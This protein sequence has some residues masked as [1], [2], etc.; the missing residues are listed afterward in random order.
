MG[1]EEAFEDGGFAG[2][3]GARD[4]DWAVELFCWCVETFV[5]FNRGT[6]GV[7]GTNLWVPLW[8]REGKQ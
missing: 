6:K 5:N 8:R 4:D 2:A 7:C 1:G 3:G